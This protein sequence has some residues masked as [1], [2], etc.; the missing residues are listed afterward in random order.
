MKTISVSLADA[1]NL[2]VAALVASNVSRDNAM[3]VARALVAAEADGQSGHGL[4]RVESYAAQARS[5]KVDGTAVPRT[6]RPKPGV[7]IVDALNGF[8]YPA[9]A[10]AIAALQPVTRELG[11]ACAAVRNSHHSGAL[12]R[13]VEMLAEAGLIGIMVSNTPK[14]MAPWGGRAPVFGTNPIAFAAPRPSG[15]ALV[16]DLSLSRAARGKIMAATKSGGSIPAGWALDSQ[17]NP[18]T[19]AAAALDGTML[20]AGEAKGAAL[21]LMVEVLAGVVAGPH[22]SF[23]ASSFFTADGL[24]PAV[25]QFMIAVD[26]LTAGPAY[27]SRIERLLTEIVSDPGARLPGERRVAARERARLEGL[28]VPDVVLEEIKTIAAGAVPQG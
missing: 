19:D 16:I 18:T 17:G 8:A 12:G 21:A 28:S 13:H 23:E 4:S 11:I 15:P 26:T 10:D 9:L 2:V 20:P 7:V 3:H 22:L 1:E 25:G 6:E 27:A 24:P 14:A 5:G